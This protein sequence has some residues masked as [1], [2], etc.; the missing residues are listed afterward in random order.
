M[1][2]SNHVSDKKASIMLIELIQWIKINN[3]LSVKF[4]N[5]CK[6]ICSLI[7]TIPTQF[8]SETVKY[9]FRINSATASR[10]MNVFGLKSR[11]TEHVN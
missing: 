8:R 5:L 2:T 11:N 6:K 1:A 3:D 7:Q 10:I 4:K 9:I